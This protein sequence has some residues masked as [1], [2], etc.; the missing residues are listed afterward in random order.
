MSLR[1]GAKHPVFGRVTEGMSV[2]DATSQVATDMKDRPL[3]EV[4]IIKAE[5]VN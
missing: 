3:Q 5:L 4:R 1:N 2:V